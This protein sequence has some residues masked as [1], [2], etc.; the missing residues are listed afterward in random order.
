LRHL[1]AP[2]PALRLL[3]FVVG[4]ILAGTA[5]LTPLDT[6]LFFSLL[7]SVLLACA[8]GFEFFQRKANPFPHAVTSVVYLLFVFSAFA[9]G[10]HYRFNT[11]PE[12]TLLDYTGNPVL[13]YGRVDGRPSRYEK[14]VGWTLEAQE[15]FFRGRSVELA[16]RA[17]IFMRNGSGGLSVELHNGDMVRVKGMLQLIPEAANRGE[18]DPR[19][20]ARMHGTHVQLFCAGPWHMERTGKTDLNF[21]ERFVV[22][23]VY[24]YIVATVD[25]LV[26]EGGERK[27]VRGVLLGER[28]VLD[29]E[30]FEAFKTTGTAHVLAVSGLNVGLLAL[31]IHVLLQRFK[32]T[33]AGRWFAFALI[34]VV[35][36]VFSYVTGN[37]PSVKRAA[38]MSM[39]LFGGET[40]G[41]RAYGVNSLAV[42]D[43]LILLFDPFD[44]FN[45]G[46]LMTNAAVLAILL[47][48]PLLYPPGHKEKSLLRAALRFLSGS[49]FVSLAAIIGVS[50]VIAYYFGT[51][52]VISLAANLPV[53][54]F[55]TVMMYSLMPMLF[56]NL[57]A[58]YL[59]GFFATS[60]WF[61][62][63]LT[64]ESAL[65]F[66]KVPFAS[67]S[68]R[69]DLVEVSSYYLLVVVATVFFRRRAWGKL[70]IALLVG[71]NVFVWYGMAKPAERGRGLVTVNLGRN[72]SLL[73]ATG[74]ETVIVDGGRNARDAERIMHQIGEYR[75]PPPVAAVQFFSKD[76]LLST[77]PVPK[78]MMQHEKRLAL[79]S[80]VI[81]RP[82]EKVL[83]I[84]TRERSLLYLSGTSRLREEPAWKADVVILAVY[85]FREKQQRQIESWLGYVK[86]KRCILLAGSFLTQ[87][88]KAALY[89]FAT[90]RPDTEIRE[91]DRQIVI[92]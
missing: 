81:G 27:L 19:R 61:L 17:R 69:P 52:S 36:L 26:P 41:R 29:R 75:F 84:R 88:D 71:L 39:V 24:D 65:F 51:F 54:F 11:V 78:R 14:G 72:L 80:M 32:V 47:V 55:S 1:L 48:Y 9:A 67:V 87:Q 46:F 20:Y 25:S 33:T 3:L 5:S 45:P 7:F 12:H 79:S 44:L 89:R 50:P 77:L 70:A 49:F 23:P 30:V 16:D 6:L 62:A 86:P 34:A 58:G 83:S 63:R 4:G 64:L 74:S 82:M 85:R 43:I 57:F 92:P 2:Y 35:L 90:R 28:E 73:Y 21:F 60:S 15:V 13:L 38:I 18:F 10:S 40:L 8:L 37:S 59:A 31:G 91:P 66:S 22:A 56:F 68:L 53:V 76:S 42:S